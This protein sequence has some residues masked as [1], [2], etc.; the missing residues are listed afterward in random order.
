VELLIAGVVLLVLA[1]T[2][3]VFRWYWRTLL[4]SWRSE[5][6]EAPDPETEREPIS[7]RRI[8]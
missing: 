3:W 8:R 7:L 2:A 1:Y 4:N 6:P 5:G